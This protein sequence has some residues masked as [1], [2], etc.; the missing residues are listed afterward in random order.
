[1]YVSESDIEREKPVCMYASKR[2]ILVCMYVSE[3]DND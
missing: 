2:E 1:M 3:R